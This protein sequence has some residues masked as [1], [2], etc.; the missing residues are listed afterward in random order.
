MGT[1]PDSHGLR[2][3]VPW[4]AVDLN[5]MHEAELSITNAL[6]WNKTYSNMLARVTDSHY[7]DDPSFF[8]ATARQRA[9][10]FLR[11]LGKWEEAK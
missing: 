3:A 4:Y 9:E 8:C 1:P 7:S 11:A 6:K 5:A 10:A 2:V